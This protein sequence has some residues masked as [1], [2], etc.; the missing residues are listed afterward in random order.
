LFELGAEGGEVVAGVIQ[1]GDEGDEPV[2]L[3]LLGADA[4]DLGF[5]GVGGLGVEDEA[6]GEAGFA[7]FRGAHFL[8]F[9]Q[10]E[11]PALGLGLAAGGAARGLVEGSAGE[12]AGHGAFGNW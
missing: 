9:G 2:A 12:E 3:S 4:G 6:G 1:A 11:A 8:F 7:F 5:G 10:L